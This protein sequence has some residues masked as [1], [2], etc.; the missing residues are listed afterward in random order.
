MCYRPRCAG[1]GLPKARPRVL[2]GRAGPQCCDATLPFP[3]AHN[4]QTPHPH[5]GIRRGRSESPWARRHSTSTRSYAKVVLNSSSFGFMRSE[6]GRYGVNDSSCVCRAASLTH[7][8]NR[9]CGMDVRSKR[10]PS[11]Q[12][13]GK[14][15][16]PASQRGLG[17]ESAR[18][19]LRGGNSPATLDVP[20][21]I[22][23]SR[24]A[25]I[26]RGCK[27]QDNRKREH[28]RQRIRPVE[29][30]VPG[31]LQACTRWDAAAAGGR[32][33]CRGWP[34]SKPSRARC[35]GVA[36]PT[37]PEAALQV[38]AG[39]HAGNGTHQTRSSGTKISKAPRQTISIKRWQALFPR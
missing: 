19:S 2:S 27:G 20:V 9:A 6:P 29:Q 3:Q 13:T 16:C 37:L 28:S 8:L 35:S 4:M 11:P 7:F 15:P 25:A 39:A 5:R 10:G 30:I 12:S 36:C 24:L 17:G 18:M 26:A 22:Q 21:S 14:A 34:C 38:T 1:G 32:G 31:T 33:A 23:D